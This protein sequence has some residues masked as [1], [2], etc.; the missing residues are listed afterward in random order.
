MSGFGA[1]SRTP[2][3]MPVRPTIA[4]VPCRTTPCRVISSSAVSVMIATSAGSALAS[5]DLMT[6]TVPNVSFTVWPV[7]FSN[8][9]ARSETTDRTAPALRT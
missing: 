2:T 3:P 8:A 4:H 9:T 5:F 6:P 1:P 7:S